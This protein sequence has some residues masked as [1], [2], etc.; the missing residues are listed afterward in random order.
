[1]KFRHC[2]T[3]L[4]WVLVA[5]VLISCHSPQREA[6]QMVRRAELLADTLP[7]STAR[8][9]DSVLRMPV[10]FSERQRMEMALL[11]AE[12]LFG[13]RGQEISPL[14]DDDFFD[15]KPTLTTSPELERAAAYYA[16]KKQ[17]DKAAHAA[18]YS[19]FIQQHYNDKTAAMQSFK[20]AELYGGLA[21]DSLT[22]AHSQYR[23]GKMLL[24]DGMKQEALAM[25]QAAELDF[26]TCFTDKALT[27]NV[28]AVCYIMQADYGKADTFLQQSLLYSEK[29]SSNKAKRKVLNNYAVLHRQQGEYEIAISI[30]RKSATIPD[31]DETEVFMFYLN[32]GK[33]FMATGE[34]DSATIYYQYLE[35][36]LPIANV[37][38]QTKV[39][40]YDALSRFEEKKGNLSTALRYRE[41]YENLL[42][43]IIGLRQEQI[44]Y[45]IQKRYNYETIQ[46]TMNQKLIR[47]QH[48]IIAVSVLAILGLVVVV[49]SKIR[50][51]RIRKQE[52]EAKA[53][54]FHFMQ[55]N[56]ELQLKH[57]TSEKVAMDYAQQLSDALK[58][59]ALIMR[60]LDIYLDNKGEASFLFDLKNAVFGDNDH[61]EALMKV[62]DTLY[63]NVRKNLKTQYPELTEMEQKDFILS[64]FNVPRDDEALMF[65]K[66]VHSVDK[67]R[68]NVRKKMQARV[69]KP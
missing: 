46:N 56:K 42:S 29:A 11:Q 21:E 64:Y 58:K 13:D 36:A 16:R 9:I 15:G 31:F 6:R 66:S 51:A 65:K 45:S 62:F 5:N 40:T 3:G 35:E 59:E 61:W 54:L 32:M 48:I 26:G 4:F 14:M 19:G 67:W 17:Y 8:L 47:R 23:M 2:I 44:V 50:L 55:Q 24:N 69:S 20:D 7:D 1:M 22:M 43:E 39:S 41:K 12:A 18:L 30:L 38:N 52:T 57:E 68:N 53:N 25:L 27:L 33:T 10:Y 63:P 49:L 28:I 37:K 60:K 34:I